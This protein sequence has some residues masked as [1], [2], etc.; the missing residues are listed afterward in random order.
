M[1]VNRTA[2]QQINISLASIETAAVLLPSFIGDNEKANKL[3]RDL[4][5]RCAEIR[6]ALETIRTAAAQI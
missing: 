1:A 5:L 2:T 4:E 6:A 3:L